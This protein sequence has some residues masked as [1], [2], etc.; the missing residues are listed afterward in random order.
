MM[1]RAKLTKSKLII[2]SETGI[3][4]VRPLNNSEKAYQILKG[5]INSNVE[6]RLD[7]LAKL[8][9]YLTVYSRVQIR[10]KDSPEGYQNWINARIDKAKNILGGYDDSENRNYL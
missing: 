10:A 5:S 6:Y 7:N 8:S 3:L 4:F 1:V 9:E 2:S